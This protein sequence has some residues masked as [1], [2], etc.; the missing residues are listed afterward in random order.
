MLKPFDRIS[1]RPTSSSFAIISVM[2]VALNGSSP[3]WPMRGAN[4][5]G[6]FALSP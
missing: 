3:D 6:E 5:A 2:V 1:F 4:A